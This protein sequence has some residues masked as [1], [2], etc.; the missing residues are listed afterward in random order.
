MALLVLVAHVEP[1]AAAMSANLRRVIMPSSALAGT[2]G[3]VSVFLNVAFNKFQK[4]A[5]LY[6]TI[7]V[8][9]GLLNWATNYLAVP[10][11][12]LAVSTPLASP[13]STDLDRKESSIPT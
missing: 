1:A 2:A 5:L 7:P 12:G 4:N 6:S 10:L 13:K 9:A 3:V 8:V 11:P